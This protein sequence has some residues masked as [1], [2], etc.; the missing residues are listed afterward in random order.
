MLRVINE[1]LI[2]INNS[3]SVYAVSVGTAGASF[4]HITGSRRISMYALHF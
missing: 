2:Q 1:K 3:E 4:L